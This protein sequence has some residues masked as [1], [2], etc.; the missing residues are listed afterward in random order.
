MNT[1]VGVVCTLF[2]LPGYQDTN[3]IYVLVMRCSSQDITKSYLLLH[4]FVKQNF[5][6][7]PNSR[8]GIRDKYFEFW[9][10]CKIFLN[11]AIVLLY[12][13]IYFSPFSFFWMNE[14]F[15]YEVCFTYGPI[16]S[17]TV[18]SPNPSNFFLEFCHIRILGCF[19]ITFHDTY[20]YFE[21]C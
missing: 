3:V 14:V 11:I 6:K 18:V 21:F 15:D 9:K 1:K 16:S 2:L 8:L 12:Y 19:R 5:V 17:F 4:F 13:L 10:F 20:N 7:A